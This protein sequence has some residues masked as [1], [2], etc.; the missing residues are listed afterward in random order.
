MKTIA[1]AAASWSFGRGNP[2]AQRIDFFGIGKDSQMYHR[3][4]DRGVWS[5]W[6]P[7]GGAFTSPPAVASW[8]SDRLDIVGLGTDRRIYHK[9]WEGKDNDWSPSHEDWALLGGVFKFPP[10][11]VSWGENRLDIQPGSGRR[12]RPR[13]TIEQRLDAAA[14]QF[15][16]DRRVVDR[17]VPARQVE[18]RV[19]NV[20]TH[21]HAAVT[22][23]QPPP[24]STL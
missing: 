11:I 9:A 13:G 20:D 6:D 7:L 24:C 14:P 12:V 4:L 5:E 18:L 21:G 22:S 1:L 8:G 15:R 2:P 19:E 16:R 10:A 3:A 23:F 17:E